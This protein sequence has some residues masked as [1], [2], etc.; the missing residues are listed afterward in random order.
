MTHKRPFKDGGGFECVDCK[1]TTEKCSDF[2]DHL[3]TVRHLDMLSKKQAAKQPQMT[4]VPTT[5]VTG[6]VA[7]VVKPVSGTFRCEPCEMSMTSQIC[8][9]AHLVSKKHKRKMTGGSGYGG[10]KLKFNANVSKVDMAKQYQGNFVPAGTLTNEMIVKSITE[11]GS[12]TTYYCKKCDCKMI[13]KAQYDIHVS[14]NRHKFTEDTNITAATIYGVAPEILSSV[15]G[16]GNATKNLNSTPRANKRPFQKHQYGVHYP[17]QQNQASG[18]G[19]GNNSA[20]NYYS[21]YQNHYF[22]ANSNYGY[23]YD[24]KMMSDTYNYGFNPATAG[25]SN[26]QQFNAYPGY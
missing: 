1:H 18:S 7:G 26:Q 22:N 3:Q 21:N 9:D 25:G 4:T 16:I 2:E 17:N 14:S 6:E 12:V 24:P 23:G 5:A 15:P 11:S 13:S 8:M 19:G 20:A 10:K